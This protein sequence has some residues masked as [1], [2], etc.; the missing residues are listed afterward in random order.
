MIEYSSSDRV[1][2][3]EYFEFLHRTDLGQQYAAKD[4]ADRVR[5]MLANLDVVITA[6]D[7]TKLI[8]VCFGITDFAYF[9]FFTDLGVDRTYV[10][11]GIGRQ[12][13]SRAIEVAGGTDNITVMTI[14]H[15]DAIPFYAKCEMVNTP[16]LVVR[17]CDDDEP[18][19]L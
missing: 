1:E 16:N 14:S 6:R 4:F 2:F 12:L 8:G 9:L 7:D 15:N 17:Y 13:V 19:L 11:Q 5:T 3:P 18:L 10:G